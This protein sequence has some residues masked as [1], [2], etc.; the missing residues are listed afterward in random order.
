MP[1]TGGIAFLLLVGIFVM[2]LLQV[3]GVL[4]K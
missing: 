3:L 2:V 4:P 1:D